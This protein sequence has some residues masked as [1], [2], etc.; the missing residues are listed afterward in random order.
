MN[1]QTASSPEQRLAAAQFD[2]PVPPTPRGRYA[3]ACAITPVNLQWVSVAGQVCRRDGVAMAG[4]C[5]NDNDIAPAQRAAE[6][7]MG[8]ALAALR[9]ACHG[10]LDRVVQIVRLRGYIRSAPTFMRH[11][12]VL[13]AASDVL[14]LAFPDHA[15]PAR[16]AIGVSSLPDQAWIEIEIDAF[17]AVR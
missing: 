3:P 17:V 2:L 7:A 6:V 11:A 16:T 8:N 14:R 4:E 9:Q 13:D 1:A 5:R 12:A 10:Q 15:L